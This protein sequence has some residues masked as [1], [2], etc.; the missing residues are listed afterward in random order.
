MKTKITYF[1]IL[2]SAIMATTDVNAQFLRIKGGMNLSNMIVE[3]NDI[4]YSKDFKNRV[5]YQLGVTIQSESDKMVSFEGGL[6]IGTRGF[7]YT[8]SVVFEG[9]SMKVEQ[10]MKLLY[11]TVPLTAKATV[12]LGN[13]KLY[14]ALGP[15]LALGLQGEVWTKVS[16]GALS[17]ETTEDI[18][19][20]TDENDNDLMRFDGGVHLGFG[21]E[22]KN[23]ELGVEYDYGVANISPYTENGTKISNKNIGITLAYKILGGF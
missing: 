8:E 3:D 12:D 7:D 6:N 9:I 20:G 16:A 18:S 19:W 23:V 11:L 21:L 13:A 15:Y 22:Y 17:E 4:T 10:K 5:G 14:A 1:T 2:A